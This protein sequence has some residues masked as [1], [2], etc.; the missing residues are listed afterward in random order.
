MIWLTHHSALCRIKDLPVGKEE[1]EGV[2]AHELSHIKNRGILIS[3]IAATFAGALALLARF[4]FY[5]GFLF[6]GKDKNNFFGS[7]LSLFFLVIVTPLIAVM[8]QLA[9]SRSREFLADAS[10]A[11]VTGNPQGLARALVKLERFSSIA[12][13]SDNSSKAT[14]HLFIVNPF[15]KGLIAGLFSTHPS[16]QK[17]VERL[18][19]LN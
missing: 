4:A 5:A 15:Q 18:N 9:I 8:L 17:R 16:T 6:P 19:A 7:L 3:S 10:S 11:K 1:L 12:P 13:L 2:I 14:A